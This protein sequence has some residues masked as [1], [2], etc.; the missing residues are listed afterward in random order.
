MNLFNEKIKTKKNHRNFIR[1]VVLECLIITL[2]LSWQH[3]NNQEQ[4]K[5][6][7]EKQEILL[8]IK[9]QADF[10]EKVQYGNRKKLIEAFEDNRK[11]LKLENDRRHEAMSSILEIIQEIAKDPAIDV[12]NVY[13]EE[14]VVEIKG[15]A[16]KKS[17]I[18]KYFVGM[19][20]PHYGKFEPLEF[21]NYSQDRYQFILR[22]QSYE[23]GG[24]GDE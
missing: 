18:D 23:N 4:M 7:M 19:N 13:L 15:S 14:S 21:N 24:Y 1:L 10:T 11:E 8:E 3:Y 16:R 20:L 5:S 22:N 12:K 2:L 17:D 9:D 6:L